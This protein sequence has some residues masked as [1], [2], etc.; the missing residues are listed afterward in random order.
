[1]Y[2]QHEFMPRKVYLPHFGSERRL[3]GVEIGV[4]TGSGSVTM[5]QFLSNL[6]LYSIDPWQHIDGAFFECGLTQE[7]LDEN[8]RIAQARLA[9]YNG[10]SIIIRKT[11]DEAILDVPD[12]IDFVFIDGDHA[13]DQV[14]RDIKNY[15]SKVRPG[16]IIAGHDFIQQDGVTRAVFHDCFKEQIIHLGEDFT[17][18]VIKDGKSN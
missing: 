12:E 13:Y 1:M 3:V 5:L 14:L 4:L 6:I 18:W 2:L 15:G 11:S 16:G 7:E 9:E 8:Y 17:W 10:R